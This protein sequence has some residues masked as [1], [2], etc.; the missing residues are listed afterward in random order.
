[1]SFVN[2]AVLRKPEAGLFAIDFWGIDR[3]EAIAAAAE[4]HL[5][6]NATEEVRR[7]VAPLGAGSSFSGLAGW[8]DTVKRR[9]PG[10]NDDPATVEFLE[11]ERNKTNDTWH[12]VN[13]P[14]QA[15]AYDRQRYPTF[16]RDDDVV[17]M[18]AHA[19]RALRGNSDRFS[20]LNALRLVIHLV[21]DVHQPIHVGC[22]YIDRSSQPAKLVLDPQ[23]AAAENLDHD[24]G[25][26]RLFLPIGNGRHL[27]GYW[28]SQIGSVPAGD[29]DGHDH[30]AAAAPELKAQF[31]QKLVEMTAAMPLAQSQFAAV[32]PE[33]WAEQWA[34]ESLAAARE[35]YSSY[36]IT[37]SRSG[38]NFDISWEGKAA[39]DARCKPIANARLAAAVSNLAALL[40]KIWS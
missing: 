1:M 14:A 25:G 6:Q 8:A 21:G 3:H 22:G 37:G 26:N 36:R 5:S 7:I 32:D 16:T 33:R 34:T 39:Y 18:I 31:V 40:N 28:D 27:H 30:F 13:I 19:V 10:P 35:A 9:P 4:M 2:D 29:D 20:E 15:D 12:Y 23:K 38:G 11:D 17:Q 24:R